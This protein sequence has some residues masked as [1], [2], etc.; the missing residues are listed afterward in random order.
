MRVSEVA[1]LPF[2]A[3]A[4]VRHARLFHPEGVLCS[5]TVLRTADPGRGLPL[6]DGQVVGRFSKGV[7][8]PGSL[9]DFAGLA[10]RSQTAG[11][12]PWDVLMV[13]A[14]TRVA[15]M[16][17]ASWSSAVFSMLM[18]LGYDGKTFWLRA[19]LSAPAQ[20]PG[21][22]IEG[23]RSRLQ[24]GGVVLD[25][26]QAQGA[27]GFE[28]LAIL[29][30]D[31]VVETSWPPKDVSFDPAINLAPGVSLLP[32][33]LTALRRRAYRSSRQGRDAQ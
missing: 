7:G 21:L 12:R 6:T 29:E 28:S 31:R 30:F 22:S 19:R 14:L 2:R 1:G 17:S 25:V 5:G 24:A 18:P 33:W 4:A 16:P 20:L 32:Q 8:L 13:S 11:G 26:E 3:G 23:I 15:L 9:P 10:W 27:G